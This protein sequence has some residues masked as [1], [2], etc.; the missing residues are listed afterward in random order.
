MFSIVLSP[1]SKMLV[2]SLGKIWQNY[3]ISMVVA[4]RKCFFVT[5]E[6]LRGPFFNLHQ[7]SKWSLFR[8]SAPDESIL[9]TRNDRYDV[10]S[11]NVKAE[12]PERV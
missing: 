7:V 6:S 4:S 10:Q 2:V 8:L 11:R 12:Q 9:F 1:M 3:Q 5:N